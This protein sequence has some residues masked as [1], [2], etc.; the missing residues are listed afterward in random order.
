[1]TDGSVIPSALGVNPFLTI[2]ALT[3]RFVERKIQE[4]GGDAYPDRP[5]R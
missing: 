5:V 1:M 3:E 4:L 2:S